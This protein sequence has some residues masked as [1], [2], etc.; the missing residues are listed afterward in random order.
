M[1]RIVK[2]N[3]LIQIIDQLAVLSFDSVLKSKGVAAWLVRVY[4]L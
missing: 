4:I 1:M 3:E 2:H